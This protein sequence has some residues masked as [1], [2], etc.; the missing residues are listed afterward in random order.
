MVAVRPRPGLVLLTL[1]APPHLRQTPERASKLR[2]RVALLYLCAAAM[3]DV[4]AADPVPAFCDSSLAAPAN[5]PLGYRQR[6][7]R[8]EGRFIKE[9]GN[10]T[11][12]VRSLVESVEPLEGLGTRPLHADW[13]PAP[14]ATDVH[15]RV[16]GVKR[17]L[18]YRLDTQRPAAAG[19]YAWPAEVLRGVTRS[20]ADVGMLASTRLAVNGSL[21]EVYLPVRVGAEPRPGD[22][23]TLVLVP[24]VALS[25]LFVTVDEI[26]SDGAVR[27]AG[28]HDQ[29]LQYGYYPAE[30]GVEIRLPL[31]S[32]SERGLVRVRIAA[33]LEAG[34]AATVD[35]WLYHA[36]VL[37]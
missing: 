1:S 21:R 20:A 19:G 34:G 36:G 26:G 7:D 25:E 13:T 32:L 12:S 17:R 9:V 29:P 8:C 3:S 15:L 23:Y 6:G 2:R 33:Q 16:Q 18:Y 27:H 28:M 11:L 4:G 37:P 24:G 5:D 31:R 30:R 10:T 14:G 35:T 22:T